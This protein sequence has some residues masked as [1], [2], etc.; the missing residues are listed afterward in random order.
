V[1]VIAAW[2]A[3]RNASRRPPFDTLADR[4]R[5]L[6]RFSAV[7]QLMAWMYDVDTINSADPARSSGFTSCLLA[8]AL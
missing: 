4:R 3:L 5:R 6:V 2:R 8:P 1:V 7:W